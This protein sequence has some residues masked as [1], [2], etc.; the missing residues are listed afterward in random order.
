MPNPRPDGRQHGYGTPAQGGRRDRPKS[1]GSVVPGPLKQAKG[2][3]P[4]NSK[5]A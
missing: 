4:F 5:K 1:A 3:R 2:T